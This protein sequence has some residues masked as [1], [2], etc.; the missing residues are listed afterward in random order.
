MASSS[1]GNGCCLFLIMNIEFLKLAFMSIIY[2]FDWQ[3]HTPCTLSKRNHDKDRA[4]CGIF[5]RLSVSI[6]FAKKE[7]GKGTVL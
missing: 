1:E 2:H 7:I 3:V 4:L 5:Y 6:L